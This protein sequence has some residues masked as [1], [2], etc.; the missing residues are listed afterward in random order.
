MKVLATSSA[1]IPAQGL[2]IILLLRWSVNTSIF[3]QLVDF[4]R[5]V[6]KSIDSSCHKWSGTGRGFRKPCWHVHQGL[7][8]LQAVQFII[9]HLTSVS[10]LGQK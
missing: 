1:P 2:Q 8:L 7:F 5:S 10:I 4:S 6:I 9:K 3:V